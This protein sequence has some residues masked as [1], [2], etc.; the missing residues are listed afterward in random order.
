MKRLIT[1][2]AELSDQATQVLVDAGFKRYGDKFLNYEFDFNNLQG[3]SNKLHD[4]DLHLD[5]STKWV[6]GKPE[7]FNVIN[8]GYRCPK[9]NG[10]DMKPNLSCVKDIN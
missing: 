4:L 5:D 2:N 3:I 9:C 1:V 6:Q 8:Q 7:T 10:L